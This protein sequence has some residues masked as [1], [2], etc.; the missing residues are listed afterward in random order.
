[1]IYIFKSKKVIAWVVVIVITLGFI[2]GQSTLSL[3][4]SA[5]KSTSVLHFFENLFESKTDSSDSNKEDNQDTNDS[6]DKETG[7]SESKED[8]ENGENDDFQDNTNGSGTD[9]SDNSENTEDGTNKGNSTNNTEIKKTR[10]FIQFLKKN[11]RKVAHF[12]EHGVLGLE[13]FFLAFVIEKL[14]GKRGKILPLNISTLI[15]TLN[16]GFIAAFLD[17]SIQI[18]SGR[19]PSVKDMWIDI[20][21]YASFT[22]ICFIITLIVKSV[23]FVF[24][25][26][27]SKANAK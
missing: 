20:A 1:M 4:E 21:G 19:G 9:S 12:V 10:P 18:L 16:I 5:D 13:V 11:F 22:A 27:K 24:I 14:K 15:L 3:S 7:D 6:S 26:Q 8:S 23:N 17:E 2:F 25:N